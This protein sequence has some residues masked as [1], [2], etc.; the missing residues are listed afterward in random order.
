VR[1]IVKAT[2]N[3][4]D[5]LGFTEFMFWGEP[6]C[7]CVAHFGEATLM[8]SKPEGETQI[9][10]NF[11]QDKYTPDAHILVDDARAHYGFCKANG[12]K[13]VEELREAPYGM[14][15]FVVQDIDGYAIMIGQDL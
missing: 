2:D 5:N 12:A 4:R 3:Y 10:P 15:E 6:P 11:S 13:I 8:L 14:L 9:L 7:W 1:D